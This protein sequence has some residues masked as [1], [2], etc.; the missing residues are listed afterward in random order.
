MRT[1][2]WDAAAFLGWLATEEEREE[3]CRPVIRAAE[4]GELVLVTSAL[5][6]AEVLWLRGNDKIPRDR[7]EEVRAFFLHKY[8]TVR[9]V[10]RTTA[11]RARE[12]VWDFNVKPKDALHVA[13]ALDTH[14]RLEKGIEQFDTFDDDLIGK[15]GNVGGDPPLTIGKPNLPGTLF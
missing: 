11:E 4:N 12:M 2:Y 7:A 6:L 10:D 14:A 8:I 5:T 13:T 15:S 3:L 9:D 1:R